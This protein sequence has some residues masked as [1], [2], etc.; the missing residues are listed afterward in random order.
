[1]S[2][3][4]TD[5]LNKSLIQDPYSNPFE[6]KM[7]NSIFAPIQASEPWSFAARGKLFLIVG[8]AG[9][10]KTTILNRAK[11][12][13]GD[14]E[15]YAFPKRVIVKQKTQDDEEDFVEA[16][17]MEF[18]SMQQN[19]EFAF[20]WTSHSGVR[21]AIRAQDVD[22]ALNAQKN[23]VIQVSRS[24]LDDVR[25]KYGETNRITAI[26]TTADPSVL[27]GRLSKFKKLTDSEV[28][29][30]LKRTESLKTRIQQITNVLTIENNGSIEE[31]V[32]K[33]L[34]ALL[35]KTKPAELVSAPP[36]EVEKETAIVVAEPIASPTKAAPVVNENVVTNIDAIADEVAKEF[37][38]DGQIRGLI[39][40]KAEES[41]REHKQ[42]EQAKK[43]VAAAT[44]TT[45]TTTITP[46]VTE[47]KVTSESRVITKT[48]KK[49]EENIFV[50]AFKWIGIVGAVSAIGVIVAKKFRLF[51]K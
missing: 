11:K 33:L 21:Y 29:E 36:L 4:N 34:E 8:P 40:K 38:G 51:G 9:A 6:T 48:Q 5:D 26:E 2:T 18:T 42:N 20:W 31:G 19:G 12:I 49:S 1:M 10:G 30:K 3:Q 7:D 22:N 50:K 44:T 43:P 24:V 27:G 47:K 23:V 28:K 46:K 15:K 14:D 17:S 25:Q 13:I 37:F 41:D 16:S 39:H 32:N 35:F 45:T